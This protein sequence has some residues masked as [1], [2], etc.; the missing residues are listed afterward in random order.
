LSKDRSDSVIPL[1]RFRAALARPRGYKR[2]DALL[3]ADD[4]AAAVAALSVTELYFLIKEVGFADSYELVA[5]ATSDQIRGCLD[6]D[7]WERDQVQLEAVA[8]WLMAL[9]DG[10]FERLGQVWEQLDPELTAL[11]IK[12]WT[13]IYDHTL[14]EEPDEDD[15]GVMFTT[16][17]TFFTTKISIGP[18]EF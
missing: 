10:G 9:M 15:E 3:S 1:S 18:M 4:P 11:I 8:P 12:Q 6:L 16:S 7:I 2:V 14:G 5:L 17:D 13:V